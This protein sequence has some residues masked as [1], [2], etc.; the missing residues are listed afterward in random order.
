[1]TAKADLLAVHY[2]HYT[3]ELNVCIT[4]TLSMECA[5]GI[6]SDCTTF[7]LQPNWLTAWFTT[8]SEVFISVVL[9]SRKN[10]AA[11]RRTTK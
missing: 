7:A 2:L 5:P 1:M 10:T 3:Q 6:V 9:P 11:R 4:E 8:G